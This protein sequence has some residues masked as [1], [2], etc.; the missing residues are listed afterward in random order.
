MIVGEV[1][2]KNGRVHAIHITEVDETGDWAVNDE[3]TLDESETIQSLKRTINIIPEDNSEEQ[4]FLIKNGKAIKQSSTH[5]ELRTSKP[6][7][8]TV[9]WFEAPRVITEIKAF[10]FATLITKKQQVVWSTGEVC[11]P[12]RGK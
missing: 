10:P 12:K 5:R 9:N 6:A 7:K 11:V 1:D 4:L 3:Y 2:Y 8:G